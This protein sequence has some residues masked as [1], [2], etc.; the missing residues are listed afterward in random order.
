VGKSTQIDLHCQSWK[1]AAGDVFIARLSTMLTS[2]GLRTEA[3]WVLPNARKG[4]V[5]GEGRKLLDRSLRPS[6]TMVYRQMM[7]ENIC[8]FLARLL[9]NPKKFRGHINLSADG[10]PYVVSPLTNELAASKENSSCPSRMAM[11]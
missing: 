10:L 2:C 3:D 7:Q 6:A 9:A 8:G 11:T 1:C 4:E 5:W